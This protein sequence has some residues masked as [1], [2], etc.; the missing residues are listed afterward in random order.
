M[1]KII[2]K[3]TFLKVTIASAL[4]TLAQ[5]ISIDAGDIENETTEVDTLDNSSPGIPYMNTG[6]VEAGK[7]SGELFFDGSDASHIAYVGFCTAPPTAPVNGKILFTNA[8]LMAFA[9]VG[10]ALL[11]LAA[12]A[13][14]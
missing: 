1:S 3:G 10:F 8:Q 5:V 14:G 12:A 13:K 6:R 11:A 2:C 9:A 4:T 7:I